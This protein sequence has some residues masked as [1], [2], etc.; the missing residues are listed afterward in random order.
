[1]IIVIG[2]MLIDIFPDYRRIGGAPFNFAFHLKKLGFPVR[3]ISRV[4]DDRQGYEILAMAKENGFDTADIQIDLRHPTGT[5]RVTLDRD[6]VPHFDICRNVAYDYLDLG[7]DGLADTAEAT[8]IY[9]G[10]L[11]QRTAAGCRQVIDFLKRQAD[12]GVRFCDI[13]L[14]P[15]H[16]NRHAVNES[17]QHADLLK[18]NE[19]ELAQIQRGF[20]G[21]P[22]SDTV[23][24]WLMKTFNLSGMVLT[25]GGRG[26]TFAWRDGIIH[27]PAIEAPAIVDTVG[28]GDGYAA[29]MA[30]GYIRRLAWETTIAQAARFAGRICTI[31]GAVPEDDAFYDDFRDP[32]SMTDS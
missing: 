10:T 11:L 12:G 31:A 28:A 18:L 6:G 1:M 16:V 15:P 20:G 27:A 9:F 14:R 22:D 19:E 32:L 30:A 26:S 24:P 4:G 2:E 23:I 5:V 25:R 3:L 7:R 29:I 21:P 17:L 13:N 8:M